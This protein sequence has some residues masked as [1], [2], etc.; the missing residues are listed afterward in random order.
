MQQSGPVIGDA[1]ATYAELAGAGFRC[2]LPN[3][4][5]GP[6]SIFLSDSSEIN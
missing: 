1:A 2:K 4:K 6:Q 5:L 3:A